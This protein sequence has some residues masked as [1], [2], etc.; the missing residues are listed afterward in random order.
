MGGCLPEPIRGARV[1]GPGGARGCREGAATSCRL[2]GRRP[3]A[4]RERE[5][6]S[7]SGREPTLRSDA[8]QREREIG[9]KREKEQERESKREREQE[10]ET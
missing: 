4:E 9:R 1:P 2:S 6:E 8:V 10:R 3:A 7:C 5:K